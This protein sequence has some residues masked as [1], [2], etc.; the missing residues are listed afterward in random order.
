MQ[1]NL[2]PNFNYPILTPEQQYDNLVSKWLIMDQ[3]KADV[4]SFL[5]HHSYF[6]MM[7][8]FRPYWAADSEGNRQFHEWTTRTRILQD[9]NFD[10]EFRILLFSYIIYIENSFKNT[11]CQ[12]TCQRLGTTRR[13]NASNFND[14]Q[15][16]VES[17]QPILSEILLWSSRHEHVQKY[18]DKHDDPKNPPFRNMIEVFTLGQV[19]K[20]YKYLADLPIKK[21]IGRQYQLD[22]AKLR[23]WMKAVV[24]ARNICC[25]HN[26]LFDKKNWKIAR[27]K[28]IEPMLDQRYDTVYHVCCL[29]QYLLKKIRVDNGFVSEIDVIIAK[30]PMVDTSFPANWKQLWK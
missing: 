7:L 12:L 29:M 9:Y 13:E 16:F 18:I 2:M 11:F 26:K 17:I 27:V 21:D 4:V 1:I 8:Y 19:V 3:D 6:R 28:V 14:Y 15:L 5:T 24:D 10:H 25:H 20:M 22:E 30:Y 23:S